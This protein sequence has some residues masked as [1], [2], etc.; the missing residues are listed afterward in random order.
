MLSE[1]VAHRLCDLADDLCEYL[2]TDQ[3]VV[4]RHSLIRMCTTVMTRTS[5]CRE[6]ASV[7]R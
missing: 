1:K 4:M 5:S 7:L 6:V 2:E 3:P